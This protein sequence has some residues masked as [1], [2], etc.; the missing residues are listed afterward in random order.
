M[1][2]TD[3][4]TGKE[5]DAKLPKHFKTKWIKALRSGEYIQGQAQLE[6]NKKYCCL[7]VACKISDPQLDISGRGLITKSHF[8][9]LIETLKIPKLLIGTIDKSSNDFNIVVTTLV[10]MNDIGK[11]FDEISTWIETHL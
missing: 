8:G 2:I 11:S 3:K 1:I 7:G 6:N 9:D 10:K 4:K 5:I